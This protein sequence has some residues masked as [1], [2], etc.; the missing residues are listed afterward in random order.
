M[1]NFNFK[2]SFE[3]LL[4]QS[5]NHYHRITISAL[6]HKDLWEPSLLTRSKGLDQLD[7][8]PFLDLLKK[9]AHRTNYCT[10]LDR[11]VSAENQDTGEAMACRNGPA[12]DK[13]LEDYSG[14]V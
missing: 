4:P 12:L 9:L 11:L 7:S 5:V 8:K 14:Q 10:S 13:L 2:A 3:R 6:V 1:A